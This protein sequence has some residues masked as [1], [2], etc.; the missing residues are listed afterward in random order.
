MSRRPRPSNAILPPPVPKVALDESLIAAINHHNA[1]HTA[2][3][4][5]LYRTILASAPGH[6][7]AS[8]GFGLLCATQG[9]LPEAIAAYRDAIAMRPDFVD[10]YINLGTA[11]L[12][13]G[14][15]EEATALYQQAIVISPGNAMAHGNLG[16]ALQDLGCIDAAIDAYRTAIALQPDDALT[17]ANFG[18]ALLECRAWADSATVTRRSIALRPHDPMAHANLGTAL[19]NF[20]RHDEALAA[21][22]QAIALQPHGAA[23]HASL[24]GAMLELGAFP[25]AII[26]CRQAISLDPAMPNAHAN[27]SHA[28]RAMNHL[29]EAAIS[30]RQAIALRPSQADFHFHLAHILLLRGDLAAGWEEYDWRWQL[31]DFAWIKSVESLASK[32]RWTGE[33]IGDKAILIHTEQGLG[34]II[35]FARYLPLVM[36]RSRHVV[37][38]ANPSMVRLLSTIEGLAVVSIREV[39]LPCFDVQCPLMS[40][41]RIFATRLDSIPASVPYLWPAKQEQ[42]RWR[43]R[44]EGTRVKCTRPRVGIVW[45]GN[46]ATVRDRFRSPGLTSVAP[47]F[48][49]PEVDFIVL[50]VG[51]RRDNFNANLLPAHVID[52]GLEIEDLADTAAVMSGLDLMI[53]SCTAPLHLAAALGVPTWAMI[54][55]APY[56]PWLLEGIDTPWYPTMRLYRQEQPGNDWSGVV[57]RIAAD[58]ADLVH[59]RQHRFQTSVE[60][61]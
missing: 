27:L 49:V 42:A 57:A 6:A 29:N 36:R 16:K 51:E 28:L 45:A 3:A 15:T 38:A 21:C 52:L 37:V 32:P 47:L 14:Q 10:A 4:E 54:P 39:S 1:G 58:L 26:L 59:S 41:P 50:Q 24:G 43:K 18:A 48:S 8:Y 55:F 22:R 5:E 19:M 35:L 25:E 20:G 61:Q 33:N 13:T 9:R 12:T 23:A 17:L 56:F 31:P 30:A 53:S 40:L 46:P 2:E 7:V 34:D 44:I 60:I 11:L